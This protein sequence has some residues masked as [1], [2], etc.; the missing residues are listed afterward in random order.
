M[1]VE[2]PALESCVGFINSG[3]RRE[4]AEALAENEQLVFASGRLKVE[5]DRMR[6]GLLRAADWFLAEASAHA[7]GGQSTRARMNEEHAAFCTNEAQR[8]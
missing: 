4:L 2:A 5:N 6:D 3:L 8:T 1:W 7:L